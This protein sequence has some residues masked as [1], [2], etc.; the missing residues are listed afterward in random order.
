MRCLENCLQCCVPVANEPA[1]NDKRSGHASF[2]RQD[3]LGVSRDH[4]AVARQADDNAVSKIPA[5]GRVGG[6]GITSTGDPKRFDSTSSPERAGASV[7][8]SKVPQKNGVPQHDQTEVSRASS[9][10]KR[11]AATASGLVAAAK[12]SGASAASKVATS[13]VGFFSSNRRTKKAEASDNSEATAGRRKKSA[14]GGEAGRKPVRSKVRGP[15]SY[16]G[17]DEA[18][19]HTSSSKITWG[20]VKTPN[21]E[22]PPEFP[23]SS[24]A[25]DYYG[26]VHGSAYDGPFDRNS[27]DSRPAWDGSPMRSR[28]AALRGLR[29]V[30]RE[31]WATDEQI[32][33]RWRPTQTGRYNGT[34]ERYID[35]TYRAVLAKTKTS[36]YMNRFDSKY[37]ELDGT[38]DKYDGNPFT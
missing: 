16:P 13:S 10:P 3:R 35:K 37:V 26:L 34:P 4:G 36:D 7:V 11:S 5:A 28:P 33:R 21:A 38:L 2:S 31:P 18:I 32:Y 24:E 9:L 14:S 27:S 23:S 1:G 25:K 22:S 29:P 30:T 20:G 19:S 15:A 17:S 6:N 8:R 12:R